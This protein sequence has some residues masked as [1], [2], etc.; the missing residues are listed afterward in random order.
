VTQTQTHV[1]VGDEARDVVVLEVRVALALQRLRE[2]VG[3]DRSRLVGVHREEDLAHA[4]DLVG[5]QA[6]RDELDRLLLEPV[7]RAE[8]RV[9]VRTVGTGCGCV[10]GCT[11]ASRCGTLRL[12]VTTSFVPTIRSYHSFHSYHS[13]VVPSVIPSVHTLRMRVTT[14]FEM[15]SLDAHPFSFIH[16]CC[17]I[18]CKVT[19]IYFVCVRIRI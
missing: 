3:R 19:R 17:R 1:G 15:G 12:R 7:A 10:D 9:E 11:R 14:S 2:L 5:R 13:F 8:L 4:V 18:S 16:S 6:R